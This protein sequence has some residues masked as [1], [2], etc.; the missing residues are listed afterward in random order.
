MLPNLKNISVL[1]KIYLK[2]L[3]SVILIESRATRHSAVSAFTETF[4]FL[5]HSLA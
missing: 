2:S 4:E 5:E 1:F 3:D